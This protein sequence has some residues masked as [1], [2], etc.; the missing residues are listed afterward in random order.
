[1]P[2]A[3]SVKRIEAALRKGGGN[4]TKA[5]ETLKMT[6]RNL[7]YRI[8]AS[9]HLQTVLV[10]IREST[11]DLAEDVLLTALKDNNL[12]AAIYITKTLG[13]ARGYSERNEITGAQGGPIENVTIELTDEERTA[14]V[15]ALLDAARARRDGS[16]THDAAGQPGA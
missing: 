8:E 1:M 3:I 5:A 16:V 9:E 10:E 2:S 13:R 7:Y 12:T 14:R 4:V 15:T 6:R 11:V